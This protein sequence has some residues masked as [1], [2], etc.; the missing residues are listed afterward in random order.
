[1]RRGLKRGVKTMPTIEYYLQNADELAQKILDQFETSS[2]PVSPE[3]QDLF[4]KASQYVVAKRVEEKR[5][6]DPA[7]RGPDR[8]EENAV[9]WAFAEAYKSY[10]EN[11]KA[12]KA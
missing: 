8:V 9:A 2:K 10:E 4:D 3:F 7:L 1:M 11:R 5:K 6:A 12:A